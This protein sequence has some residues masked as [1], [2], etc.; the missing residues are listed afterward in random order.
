MCVSIYLSLSLCGYSNTF[1]FPYFFLKAASASAFFCAISFFMAAADTSSCE[2]MP[3]LCLKTS[4]T[5]NFNLSLGARR[6]GSSSTP[7][8]S[9]FCEHDVL[10]CAYSSSLSVYCRSD[11]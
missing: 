2:L 1:M 8:D 3:P 7:S 4:V 5:S 11:F 10:T 6:S 9:C